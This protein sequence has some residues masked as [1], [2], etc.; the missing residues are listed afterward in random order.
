MQNCFECKYFCRVPAPDELDLS[1]G[2]Y[3]YNFHPMP[4]CVIDSR[5][6]TNEEDGEDCPCFERVE[7]S[8]KG[9]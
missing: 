7:Q 1:G 6:A 2:C 4:N 3:Y 8:P 5:R 9:E